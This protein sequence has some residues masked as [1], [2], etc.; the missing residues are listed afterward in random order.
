MFLLRRAKEVCV[1]FYFL[2]VSEKTGTYT[3]K[4][5]HQTIHIDVILFQVIYK[6]DLLKN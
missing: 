4:L 6:F 3:F 2:V 1:L 5:T